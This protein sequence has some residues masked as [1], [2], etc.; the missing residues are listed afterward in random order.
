MTALR[1]GLVSRFGLIEGYRSA[2]SPEAWRNQGILQ[3]SRL[4]VIGEVSV[5]PGRELGNTCE[6]VAK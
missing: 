3:E 4:V 2:T 6:R 1:D 5:G